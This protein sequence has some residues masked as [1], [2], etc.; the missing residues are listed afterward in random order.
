MAGHARDFKLQRM[1]SKLTVFGKAFVLG[2]FY[3][4]QTHLAQI[5]QFIICAFQNTFFHTAI[6]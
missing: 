2:V 4:V 1:S 5:K 3:D 6:P